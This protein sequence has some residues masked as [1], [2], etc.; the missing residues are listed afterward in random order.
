VS[1][2]IEDM[3]AGDLIRTQSDGCEDNH[4]AEDHD[5]RTGEGARWWQWN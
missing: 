5:D 2:F 3:N 4:E 1:K